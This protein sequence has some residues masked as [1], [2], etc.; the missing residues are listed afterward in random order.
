MHFCILTSGKFK[1]KLLLKGLYCKFNHSFQYDSFNPFNINSA[2]KNCNVI[3]R[4]NKY[5]EHFS[6]SIGLFLYKNEFFKVQLVFKSKKK[7]D[8]QTKKSEIEL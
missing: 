3:F 2:F 7:H 5:I 4:T 8:N 1:K 6:Y